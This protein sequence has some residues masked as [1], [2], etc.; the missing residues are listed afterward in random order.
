RISQSETA[1]TSPG[2]E[3]L[4]PKTQPQE[5]PGPVVHAVLFYHPT[6]PHCHELITQYLIPLQEQHGSQLVILGMDTSQQWA[7]N[8]YWEAVR[9]YE[10]PEE[11]WAVP[12]MVVGENAFVGGEQIPTNFSP[13]LD[14]GLAGEG[15]DLP[16]Y[17]AL[18][19]FLR[20][21]NALDPRYPNR[22]I[23]RQSQSPQEA[24]PP[25]PDSSEAEE[26]VSESDTAVAENPPSGDSAS[27]AIDAG[28][29][30]P[31]PSERPAQ[32]AAAT[33]EP[34]TGGDGSGG[35]EAP[36]A[37]EPAEAL[38]RAERNVGVVGLEEAAEELESMTMWDRFNLDRTGNSLSVLVLALMVVSLALRGYP[39]RVKGGEWPLWITPAL[40]LAGAGVAAYLSFVEVTQTQA[41]C[42]PVG[43]CN[44]VNQSEYATLFGVLPV[45]LL[46]L[47]GYGV[48]LVSWVL[49][50]SSSAK[51][52]RLAT[53]SLWGA[54]LFG[55]LFS[56][57]LTFLE[58][59]V[60]GATCAWCLTSAVV[61]TLLLWATSP[62]ASR[63]WSKEQT[64]SEAR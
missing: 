26:S 40:I 12:M 39:P 27:S 9:H 59:F 43:D 47:I 54:V 10:V 56:V 53:L 23:A 60:I 41:V 57:Y 1:R 4:L 45:G 50:H 15:V 49:R 38:D 63:V 29:E 8:L 31:S 32:P 35:A 34:E 55:T 18:V 64:P 62:L 52:S 21:Q 20:E 3:V 36:A 13:I 5:I 24:R 61:L 16:S 25:A 33:P 48:I 22:L 11:D 30:T 58:P 14:Q 44:T 2:V 51:V 37:R 6:C 46:G 28:A 42:G 17:P 19:T 7:N